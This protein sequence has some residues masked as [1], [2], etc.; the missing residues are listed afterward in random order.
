MS[1]NGSGV[2]NLPS[3]NP[4]VSGT[5]ITTTWANTTLN[6]IASA[7]TGS[8]SADGQTPM[9][10]SL[11]MASQKIINLTDP[12][13]AQDAATKTYVDASIPN[14][15]TFLVKTN[16]LSDVTSASTS[17]TN[18]GLGS[19]ATQAANSVA[20]TGGA[21]DGATVGATTA[22]TGRFTTV[23]SAGQIESKAT[24]FKFPD[25][26]IQTKA[27]LPLTGGTLSGG[28]TLSSAGITFSSST[29]QTDASIGYGQTWQSPTRASGTT[30]TNS[31]GK[32]IAVIVS[33][34]INTTLTIVV[35]GVTIYN[36]TS[37][38]T[39]NPVC[40]FLVSNGVTYSATG[41]INSW[42]ELR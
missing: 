22:N 27:G 20:I 37:A 26:T 13:N 34:A 3:G 21:I 30:Y 39:N 10:G 8:V 4:V 18:L 11:N 2:Y 41:T 19:I 40:T 28:L 29:A 6:D 17:R 32:T 23:E 25:G 33:G 7:L 16:N 42:V 12:T 36:I 14:T 5:T 38:Y 31:T 1:R 15:S 35:G 24:G 9:S